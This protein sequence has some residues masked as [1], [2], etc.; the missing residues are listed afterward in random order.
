MGRPTIK[1][2]VYEKYV[3]SAVCPSMTSCTLLFPPRP[4]GVRTVIC[5]YE[6]AE[7][8]K[9]EVSPILAWTNILAGPK[10][11]PKRVISAPP[12]IGP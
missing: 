11:D 1:T 2:A 9:A 3:Y 10:F 4:C 8:T 6:A 7:L 5:P 12:D